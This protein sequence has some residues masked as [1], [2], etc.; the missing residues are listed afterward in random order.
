MFLTHYEIAQDIVRLLAMEADPEL[1]GGWDELVVRIGINKGQHVGT[2]VW[3]SWRLEVCT[4]VIP[5]S[6]TP[7]IA[8]TLRTCDTTYM[9]KGQVITKSHN[10]DTSQNWDIAEKALVCDIVDQ[11]LDG[12]W[13]PPW[14]CGFCRDRITG[15]VKPNW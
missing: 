15:K 8:E 9:I 10:K 3:P 2:I 1:K 7:Y 11:F 13:T 4:F 5:E 6:S 14:R 12:Q